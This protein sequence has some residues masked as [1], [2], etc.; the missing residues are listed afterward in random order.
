MEN[1]EKEI[2]N[3]NDQNML[4][5]YR[6]VKEQWEKIQIKNLEGTLMRLKT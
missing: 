1:L 2:I 5:N 4:D 6:A 3:C